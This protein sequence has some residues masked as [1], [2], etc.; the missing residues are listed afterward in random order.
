MLEGSFSSCDFIGTSL[1]LKLIMSESGGAQK[2]AKKKKSKRS[3]DQSAGT[4]E[5]QSVAAGQ[6]RENNASEERQEY[7]SIHTLYILYMRV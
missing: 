5:S 6:A 3:E 4:R 2:V 7:A 1:A